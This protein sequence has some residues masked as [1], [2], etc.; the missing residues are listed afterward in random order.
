MRR[1]SGWARLWIVA[2]SLI[3]GTGVFLTLTTIGV[4]PNPNPN[5]A[6]VCAH[7]WLDGGRETD[8]IFLRECPSNAETLAVARMLYDGDASAYPARLLQFALPWALAPFLAAAA[9]AIGRWIQRG[10]VGS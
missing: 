7:A 3:W 9:W 6:T 2:A 8:S 1:L 10:F 5:D 4:P